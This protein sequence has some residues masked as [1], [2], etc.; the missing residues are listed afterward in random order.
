MAA[1]AEA[2]EIEFENPS[3]EKEA[4]VKALADVRGSPSAP[5]RPAAARGDSLCLYSSLRCL[6]SKAARRALPVRG[7]RP[8]HSPADP[9]AAACAQQYVDVVDK[10]Y[11]LS[12][13]LG[14]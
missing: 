9:S 1:S 6:T 8:L 11:E 7:A 2:V 5:A 10:I 3:P 13:E 12:D 4:R 14:R